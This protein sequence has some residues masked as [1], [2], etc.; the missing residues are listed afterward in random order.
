MGRETCVEVLVK[1]PLAES[2]TLPHALGVAQARARKLH[3]EVNGE[4]V[5]SVAIVADGRRLEVG[6]EKLAEWVRS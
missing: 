6:A 5:A 1:V 2:V 3:R 4:H